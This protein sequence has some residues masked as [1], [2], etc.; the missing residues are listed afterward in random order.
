MAI[1]SDIKEQYRILRKELDEEIDR[2]E[3]IHS[4]HLACKKRCDLCC[5]PFSVF[6]V[7][8][9]VIKEEF[10]VL[11]ASETLKEES[12]SV[13]TC[14][15]LKNHSC[16]IYESRPFICRTHGLPLLY[17]ENE[18]WVLSHCEL[19]FKDADEDYFDESDMHEQDKWN[20]KLYILNREYLTTSPYTSINEKTLLPLSGLLGLK[21]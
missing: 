19:N 4:N 7:E 1:N 10:E 17:M 8:Y 15:F 21:R 20:S 16:S 12:H 6:P 11:L 5:M 13:G 2:L 3:S 18:E 9:E 14:A